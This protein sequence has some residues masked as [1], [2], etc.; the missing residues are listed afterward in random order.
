MIES[1]ILGPY[2]GRTRNSGNRPGMAIQPQPTITLTSR[3]DNNTNTY[4]TTNQKPLPLTILFAAISDS[5]PQAGQGNVV[6]GM[7]ILQWIA[8]ALWQEI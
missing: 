8:E 5:L 1:W 2:M 6:F 3:F 7:N 4:V